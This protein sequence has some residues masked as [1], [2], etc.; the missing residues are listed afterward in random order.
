VDR[1]DGARAVDRHRRRIACEQLLYAA[2][3]EWTMEVNLPLQLSDAVTLTSVAALW[4]PESA[5][6]V[7]LVYFW[8][9]REV[10]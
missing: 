2:R 7:E 5:V 9:L 4:R 1:P 3:H 10:R 8:A 6:L